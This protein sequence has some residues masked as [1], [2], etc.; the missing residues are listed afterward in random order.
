MLHIS[1]YMT[2]KLQQKR[3]IKYRKSKYDACHILTQ[4]MSVVSRRHF[5]LKFFVISQKQLELLDSVNDDTKSV[6]YYT[7]DL[8]S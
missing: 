2:Y 3:R 1:I 8:P 6:F 5:K 7:I 4:N